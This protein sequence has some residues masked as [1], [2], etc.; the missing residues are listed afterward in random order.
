MLDS[1][2]SM[3]RKAF[4]MANEKVELMD[5]FSRNSLYIFYPDVA[6]ILGK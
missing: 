1:L 5:M 4:M 6:D 3:K 2:A